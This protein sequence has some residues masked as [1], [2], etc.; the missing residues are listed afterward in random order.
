MTAEAG[1]MLDAAIA[2]TFFG[3][4]WWKSR[5]TGRRCIYAPGRNPEHMQTPSDKTEPLV[6]DW[7]RGTWTPKY[8]TNMADAW[9]VVEA[10]REHPTPLMTNLRLVAYSYARTY[11]TFDHTADDNEWS[12]ANGEH[13]TPLAICLAALSVGAFTP[14][15]V[16]K[17]GSR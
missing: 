3:Y 7:E 13:A 17:E 14:R 2:E 5:S 16:A 9:R 12:E 11:A 6:T 4:Q 1:K 10:M 8:S 15:S